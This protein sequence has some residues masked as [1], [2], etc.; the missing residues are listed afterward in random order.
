MGDE[1]PNIGDSKPLTASYRSSPAV[2]EFVNQLFGN[3]K[4]YQSD[5]PEVNEAVHG[6]SQ[7]FAEHSTERKELGGC[8]TVEYAPEVDE[9]TSKSLP[10]GKHER[11]RPRNENVVVKTIERI[12]QLSAQLPDERFKIG[13]LVRTN[14]EV[15]SLIFE[16]QKAG[17]RA[18]EEGGNPLTD[19]ASVEYILS[20]LTLA[21]HPGDDIARFHVSH[22]FLAEEMGLV[23]END[24]NQTENRRGV[25]EGAA[26]LR[27][28]LVR[29]G[30][31][32]TVESL[33]KL[34]A[35]HCTRREL[36]RLQHLVRIAYSASRHNER[37]SL[38]P[39]Q[40]VDFVRYE[41]KVS[42]Q[43]SAQVRVMTIHQSKGLEFD[44]V[45][46]PFKFVANGWFGHQ[47]TVVVGREGPTSPIDLACRY[48]GEDFRSVLPE[49]FQQMFVAN[50]Q[51]KVRE[52]LCNLYVA[53][54][55]AVHSAHLILSYSCKPGDKS[56]PGVL[57]SSLELP[58]EEGVVFETGN[59]NWASELEPPESAQDPYNLAQFYRLESQTPKQGR[60]STEAVG[61]RGLAVN[62]PSQMEGGQQIKLNEVFARL[63][64][65]YARIRGTMIHGCFEQ[66]EW[67]DRQEPDDEQLERSMRKLDATLENYESYIQEFRNCLDHSAI[68][69]LLTYQTYLQDFAPQF[70]FGTTADTSN[71]QL[72][73]HNERPFAVQLNGEL[74]NG[75]ID[76][77]VLIY[78]GGALVGAD[79]IDFKTDNVDDQSLR[80]KL[81]YYR[82]QLQSYREA[83]SKMTRLPMDQVGA[84]LAFVS[85]GKVVI[86]DPGTPDSTGKKKNRKKVAKKRTRTDADQ[87]TQQKRPTTKKA[88]GGQQSGAAKQTRAENSENAPPPPKGKSSHQQ[89]TF[90]DI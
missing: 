84:R 10:R 70:G 48:V 85:S 44:V 31:G 6:W 15:G 49:N 39:K 19:A 34:L 53:M 35:P 38:R 1:L 5:D 89:K 66:V 75:V 65:Q 33:A 64:N 42:D 7:W 82:P 17:I 4:R 41:V 60:V 18:S 29:D 57:L 68:S 81:M 23:P 26:N 47:P 55:R 56:S 61:R 52:E 43:S 72:E 71:Y 76:R 13:V 2:I 58:R 37:W 27:K 24:A 77:L 9:E 62:S 21:D 8:V 3:L 59:P 73:V 30:Y 20:A 80:E 28:R 32:P 40:F 50:R 46:L 69:K 11:V 90:W 51:Q 79:I 74:I 63:D 12:T 67:L 25:R 36:L 22:S 78:D 86:V 83:V 87:L 45:V 14:D 54:T 88:R 16:L